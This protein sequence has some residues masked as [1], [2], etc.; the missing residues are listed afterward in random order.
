MNFNKYSILGSHKPV[1]SIPKS[2]NINQN[3]YNILESQH[4]DIEIIPQRLH[5]NQADTISL[6]DINDENNFDMIA[7]QS[8]SSNLESKKSLARNTSRWNHSHKFQNNTEN[9]I[10]KI[11]L[12]FNNQS[13][14]NSLRS[15]GNTNKNIR[16]S[17]ETPTFDHS[18]KLGFSELERPINF[19]N[20]LRIDEDKNE[21]KE[22]GDSNDALQ[23]EKHLSCEKQAEPQEPQSFGD[24]KSKDFSEISEIW[25]Q[26][27]TSDDIQTEKH[28][29]TNIDIDDISN[30]KIYSFKSNK[31][32]VVINE[33]ETRWSGGNLMSHI[34][35]SKVHLAELSF[36]DS[37]QSSPKNFNNTLGS[38]KNYQNPSFIKA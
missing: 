38:F 15:F 19:G 8:I 3:S 5:E 28:N 1:R 27:H 21:D 7:C 26:K 14:K 10:L 34:R 31:S 13:A 35:D 6:A 37:I 4:D 18:F 16:A 22:W 25:N 2:I 33:L 32:G 17:I 36:H 24:K 20:S 9:S 23:L 11:D 30:M 29:F 12:D